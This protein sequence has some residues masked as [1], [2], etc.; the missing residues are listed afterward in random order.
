MGACVDDG[1]GSGWEETILGDVVGE[2]RLGRGVEESQRGQ[3]TG[4][5]VPVAKRQVYPLVPKSSVKREQ[6]ASVVDTKRAIPEAQQ[7]T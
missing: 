4:C 5:H 7:V 3:H 6:P 1:L 2:D